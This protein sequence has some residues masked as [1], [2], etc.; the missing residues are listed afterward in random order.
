[1]KRLFTVTLALAV[2]VL[3][4]VPAYSQMSSAKGSAAIS[5]LT[6]LQPAEKTYSWDPILATYIKVPQQKELVFDVSLECGLMTDTLV[7]SKGG[8]QDKSDAKATVQVRVKLEPVI[9]TDAE[10]NFIVDEAAAF[11]AY[12]G[13]LRLNEE[14]GELENYGVTYCERKQELMAKFGGFDSCVDINND[15][16]ITAD[17][18]ILEEE[19][20]QLIL[21]TLSANAFNFV[22]ANLDQGEYK[23]TVEAEITTSVDA[24]N[25]SANAKGWVGMGSLVVDEVRFINNKEE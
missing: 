7:R 19:E 24:E 1:M 18:C 6:L 17:E 8:N 14:T 10:G 12:P 5:D 16:T 3:L 11:Y 2:F 15:Q 21:N 22:S 4:A 20:L 9:G 23:V 25:G 13:G